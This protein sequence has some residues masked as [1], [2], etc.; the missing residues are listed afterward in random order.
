MAYCVRCG[1]KLEDRLTVCPLCGTPV[2]DPDTLLPKTAGTPDTEGND[3]HESVEISELLTQPPAHRLSPK[4]A[5]LSSL[6]LLVP[7]ITTLVI[8]IITHNAVTWSFYPILS[9]LYTWFAFFFPSLFRLGRRL[10]YA[11]NFGIAT[12]IYL[13]L[14]DGFLPPVSWAWYPIIG[15]GLIIVI[16]SAPVLFGKRYRFPVIIVYG[17]AAVLALYLIT[18]VRGSSWFTPLALPLVLFGLALALLLNGL[19]TIGIR[20][21]RPGFSLRFAAASAVAAAVYGF[22]TDMVVT[23]YLPARTSLGWS[24]ITG[25]VLLFT[26]V[27]LLCISGS[28]RL[29]SYA[30]K[31]FHA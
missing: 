12:I 14:L 18:L 9:L 5:A 28:S 22:F 21:G 16:L 29:R 8:D 3:G 19:R 26:A 7:I 31:K 20:R 23:A 24:C 27:L 10:S 1:V 2:I 30:E 11:V 4:T 25:P 15:I 13:L 17:A 6:A